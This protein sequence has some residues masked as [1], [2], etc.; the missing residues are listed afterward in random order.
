MEK[1]K[2]MSTRNRWL[3]TFIC[4]FCALNLSASVNV[5]NTTP[6]NA[7]VFS[8]MRD[9]NTS[10]EAYAI[11]SL[12]LEDYKYYIAKDY[13]SSHCGLILG[14]SGVYTVVIPVIAHSIKFTS[15]I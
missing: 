9:D 1:S 4:L 10:G 3:T 14:K 2:R 6:D 7:L 11:D 13:N 12:I 15:T 5:E 8:Y